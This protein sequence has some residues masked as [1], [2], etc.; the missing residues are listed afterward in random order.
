SCVHDRQGFG[1]PARAAVEEGEP[2]RHQ[3]DQA[4]GEEHEA[5]VRSVEHQAVLSPLSGAPT[6]LLPPLGE[7]GRRGT[8]EAP[9]VIRSGRRGTAAAPTPPSASTTTETDGGWTAAARDGPPV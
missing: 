8:P 4:R 5:G 3:H 1:A 2:G 7:K 9:R 6:L